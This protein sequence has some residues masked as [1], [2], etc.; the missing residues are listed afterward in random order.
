MKKFLSIGLVLFTLAA[1]W[2]CSAIESNGTRPTRPALE[3]STDARQPPLP[4][5]PGKFQAM[6]L[7]GGTVPESYGADVTTAFCEGYRDCCGVAPESWNLALCQS[8]LH[9]AGGVN[10]L[11]NIVLGPG[12]LFDGDL[13]ASC[14]SVWETHDCTTFP[15][16]LAISVNADCF[17]AIVGTITNG[18]AC[19]STSECSEGYCASG[20]C[21]AYVGLGDPCSSGDQCSRFG[22]NGAFCA[23]GVCEAARAN[24]ESCSQ[25]QQCASLICDWPACGASIPS[26]DHE[27]TC[28]GYTLPD[29]GT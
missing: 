12:A 26:V 1:L 28:P 19:A 24:S 18:N 14:I 17:G 2:A 3:A 20:T 10:G 27:Y 25:N 6:S 5:T 4:P 29:G 9:G 13:A 16:S 23:G 8:M 11:E 21:T 7:D 22:V 15:S